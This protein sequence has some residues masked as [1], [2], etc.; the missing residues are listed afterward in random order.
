VGSWRRSEAIVTADAAVG[1][2]AL[3]VVGAAMM[4]AVNV[5]RTVLMIVV[6]TPVVAAAVIVVVVVVAV[7]G[8]SRPMVQLLLELPSWVSRWGV[9]LLAR[10]DG[11][12]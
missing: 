2:G 10:K 5:A 12:F 3:G 9:Q 4:A 1:T 8:G 11:T 7:D 6:A